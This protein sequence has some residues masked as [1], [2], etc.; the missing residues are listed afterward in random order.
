MTNKIT[1]EELRSEISLREYE[2]S[3]A[4]IGCARWGDASWYEDHPKKV[5]N[6]GRSLRFSQAVYKFSE[7]FEQGLPVLFSN[8]VQPI[9]VQGE[10]DI[11]SDEEDRTFDEDRNQYLNSSACQHLLIEGVI[12]QV[13]IESLPPDSIDMEFR[14]FED[15]SI[16]LMD[17]VLGL[18]FN[19]PD[20][21]VVFGWNFFVLKDFIVQFTWN[22]WAVYARKGASIEF[23]RWFFLLFT[24][25]FEMNPSILGAEIDPMI[26]DYNPLEI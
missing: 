19:V 16:E 26:N 10:H 5:E 23:V 3:Y 12:E 11:E 18:H 25:I 24:R 4:F 7:D 1:I 2:R 21:Y 6:N 13:S 15:V 14:I 9:Y 20:P 17:S 22:G 8:L